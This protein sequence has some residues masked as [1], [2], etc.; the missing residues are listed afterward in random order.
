MGLMPI[1]D[2]DDK[3]EK[4]GE[5]L[6]KEFHTSFLVRTAHV[7]GSDSSP[8]FVVTDDKSLKYVLTIDKK[9]WSEL[10]TQEL[11]DYIKNDDAATKLKTSKDN[12]YTVT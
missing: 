10:D 9:I 8:E 5:Y 3:I 2:Q 6:R 4:V 7:V 1:E 11:Y 12:K